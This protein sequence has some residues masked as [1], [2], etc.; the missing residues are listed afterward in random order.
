[1]TATA[2]NPLLATLSSVPW[3][4]IGTQRRSGAVAPLFSIYTTNSCGIGEF[5]DLRKLIDWCCQTGMSIIQLLPMNDVGFNFRPYDAQSSF[6]LEP[7]YLSLSDVIR[8]AWRVCLTGLR[9]AHLRLGMF[10]HF[11]GFASQ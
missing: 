10:F 2:V 11:D 6:A 5:P 1:M 4:R 8:A 7:M 3:A 9:L